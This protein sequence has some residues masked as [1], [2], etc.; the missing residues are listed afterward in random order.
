MIVSWYIPVLFL[1]VSSTLGARDDPPDGDWPTDWADLEQESAHERELRF[2][3]QPPVRPVHHH[4]HRIRLQPSTLEDGWVEV[5]QCHYHLD[6]VAQSQI[7]FR[8]GRV[9]DL[10]IIST[11]KVGKAWVE[12]DSVQLEA[13]ERGAS[14]CL[15][16]AL[17]L[18]TRVS[19]DAYL[20]RSGPFMRRFL[21]GYFPL[22]V[23]YELD[24][25]GV[26]IRLVSFTPPEQ[27]GFDVIQ[28]H[29]LFRFDSWFEGRLDINLFF[30]R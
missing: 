17:K 27:A 19:E 28:E 6:P 4:H 2:L 12:D 29:S 9:R 10:K 24:Y 7:V 14:I 18:V 5:E 26:D 25:Q 8:A 13:V 1:L 22:R 11:V 3:N 21:D 16:G 30:K 20:L 15:R 23:S